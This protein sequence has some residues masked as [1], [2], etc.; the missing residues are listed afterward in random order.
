MLQVEPEMLA[1]DEIRKTL[2]LHQP[3]QRGPVDLEHRGYF[4]RL[5]DLT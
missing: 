1:N 3:P 2:M 4:I 5:K